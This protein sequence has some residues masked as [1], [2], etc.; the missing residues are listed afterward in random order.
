M[1]TALLIVSGVQQKVL[2]R[3][4]CKL[5]QGD[6]NLVFDLVFDCDDR[7]RANSESSNFYA[8]EAT[9]DLSKIVER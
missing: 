8:V 4:G 5:T 1:I 2:R 3:S 6:C 7:A 9:S